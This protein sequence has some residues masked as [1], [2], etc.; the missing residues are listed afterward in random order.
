MHGYPP[1]LRGGTEYSVQALARGLAGAGH[2]A[3]VVA[4]TLRFADSIG[5][6]ESL[7]VDAESGRSVRVLR[8]NRDDLHFEHWQ[9]SLSPRL[10]DRFEEILRRERPDVVHVHHWLRLTRDLVARAARAG[11][12]AVVTLHDYWTSCPRTHRLPDPT[13]DFCAHPVQPAPCVRC[14][15]ELVPR[16]PWRAGSELEAEVERRTRDVAR[17]LALAR[18]VLALSE[19]QARTLPR[20]LGAGA[21]AVRMQVLPPA[22][23]LALAP[24]APLPPPDRCGRLVLCA[25]GTV[26]AVKG[27]D[28]VVDAIE[29]LARGGV[30]VELRVLGAEPDPEY[31]ARLRLAGAG[32]DVKFYGPFAEGG[33]A[34]HHAVRAHAFVSG[35]RAKETWGLVVEE[36]AALGLP[37]VLPRSGALPEHAR[38]GVDALFFAPRSHKSLAAVLRRLATEAGLHARLAAGVRSRAAPAAE[39]A[40]MLAAVEDVYAAA[41]RAGAPAVEPLPAAAAERDAAALAGWDRALRAAR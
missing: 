15:A 33:L 31:S 7:D 11:V 41:I 19:D 6:E 26:N 10:G 35:T 16:T 34:A 5:V 29:L 40:G 36:A 8:V 32:L 17:E 13:G 22:R 39:F 1:E 9:K 2:T 28:V 14:V 38:E 20:L 37:V 18:T 4:G 23:P 3:V 24:V 27:L 21:A 25:W 12:P 30:R